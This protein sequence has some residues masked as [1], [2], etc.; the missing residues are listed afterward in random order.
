MKENFS[1]TEQVG[2]E[3]IQCLFASIFFHSLLGFKTGSGNV[4]A[5]QLYLRVDSSSFTWR[6]V[7]FAV[8]NPC[9]IYHVLQLHNPEELQ[10][11]TTPITRSTEPC[12]VLLSIMAWIH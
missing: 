9:V 2:I 6:T 4:K 3:I 11:I 5:M 1:L 7:I 10:E 12:Y 8:N